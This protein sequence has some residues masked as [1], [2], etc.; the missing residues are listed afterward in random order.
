MKKERNELE[1]E[2]PG[3]TGLQAADLGFNGE[4]VAALEERL[5]KAEA[6]IE[7]LEADIKL[8]RR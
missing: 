5:I 4:I 1:I 7:K 2:G 8:C 3:A 6:R